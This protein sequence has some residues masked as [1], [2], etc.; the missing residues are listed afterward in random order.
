MGDWW[1]IV[2]KAS[3][4]NPECFIMKP[5]EV[6]RFA[7][8]GEREGRVSYW[9]SPANITQMNSVR[10]GRGLGPGN[11]KTLV[12]AK[13]PRGCQLPIHH[14]TQPSAGLIPHFEPP[15][16]M[17]ESFSTVAQPRP[18]PIKKRRLRPS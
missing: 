17:T 7:H 6:R 10:L 4:N 18:I 16:K 15:I 8:R 1:I 13:G 2:T 9:L 5:E 11:R 12:E 14:S 3:T